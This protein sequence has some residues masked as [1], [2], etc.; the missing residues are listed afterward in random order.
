MKAEPV[1]AGPPQRIDTRHLVALPDEVVEWFSG[2]RSAFPRGANAE[3]VCTVTIG[4]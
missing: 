3:G 4:A 2:E 1:R